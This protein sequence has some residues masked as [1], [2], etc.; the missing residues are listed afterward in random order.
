MSEKNEE[1]L[2]E[3]ETEVT[4]EVED[5][6]SEI[7]IAQDE[8]SAKNDAYLRLMAEYDNFRKRTVKEKD[9]IRKDSVAYACQN[10]LPVYDTLTLAVSQMEDDSP[11]KK[12]MELTLKQLS[13]AF[14]KLGIEPILDDVGTV[15]DANSHNAVMHIED[16]SLGANVIAET[17]QKGFKIG[18]KVIR[19]STVKVAN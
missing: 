13:D 3:V 11:H 5:T 14:E 10:M 19:H 12:G 1:I 7:E 8:L 9:V 17:F 2:E 15:F 4:E 18:D 16:D 6:R